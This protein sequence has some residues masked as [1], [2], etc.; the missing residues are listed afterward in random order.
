MGTVQKTTEQQLWSECRL[1]RDCKRKKRKGLG[2]A[3]PKNTVKRWVG[4]REATWLE[5]NKRETR[6]LRSH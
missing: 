2:A 3:I 5:R 1:L 4:R 6:W